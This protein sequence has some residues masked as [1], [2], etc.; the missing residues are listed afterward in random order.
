MKIKILDIYGYGKWVHQSFD[1]DASL[2]V[3]YGP[4][5][6]GKST[7]QSFIKSILFGFPDKRKRKHL[8]NRYEPKHSDI[9]GGRILIEHE[10]LGQ[11]WVERTSKYLNIQTKDGESLPDSI[12]DDILGGLDETLFDYFYGFNIQNLQDLTNIGAEDLN[13]FFLSIGTLGSDKFL[14]VAQAFEKDQEQLYKRNGS[15]PILNQRL[16]DYRELQDKLDKLKENNQRYD[17]L[18]TNKQDEQGIIA[19]LEEK[20]HDLEQELRQTDQL[21]SRYTTYLDD[22][23]VQRELDRLVYTEM[24]S[25][26]PD[27][28]NQAL[29]DNHASESKIAAL[30]ERMKHIE[31][32]LNQLTRLSWARRHADQRLKWKQDIEMAKEKQTQSEQLFRQINE[33]EEIMTHLAI[34]GKFYPEKIKYGQEYEE[35]MEA[36]LTLQANL[37]QEN[38]RL[39]NLNSECKVLLEQRRQ[40]QNHSALT[41]QQVAKLE[42]QRV[43]DEERL[44]QM[45]KLSDYLLGLLCTIAGIVLGVF[46]FLQGKPLTDWLMLLAGGMVL[47]GIMAMVQIFF[48]HRQ[49]I[50]E[51][52]ANPIHQ[53][54][55]EL[56]EDEARYLEQSRG[57]GLEINQRQG[58]I[59]D[60][61]DNIQAIRQSQQTWLTELGFYPDADPEH[62]LKTNP[63]K[64]Y[65][66]AQERHLK[67]QTER[68]QLIRDL[69]TWRDSLKE[70]M[71]RFPMETEDNN[72]RSVIRHVESIEASLVQAVMR[73]EALE[74][75]QKMTQE[76]I[77]EEESK[78]TQRQDVIDQILKHTQSE[79]TL[80]FNHKVRINEEIVNLRQSHAMYQDQIGDHLSQLQA[81]ESKQTLDEQYHRQNQA[82][83]RLK[84]QLTPHMH[85]LANIMVEID[86]LEQDGSYAQ[87]SQTAEDLK[88]EI[89]DLVQEWAE[90]RIAMHLII[91]T[92]KHGLENPVPEMNQRVNEIFTQL[93]G[94]R[95]VEVK[96]NKNHIKVRQFSDLMFEP[97]ELSQGTLEQ[98]YVALRLAFVESAKQR[99]SMPLII[100]DAF[101]N[102]DE[103]RRRQMYLVLKDMS[104]QHQILFFTFDALAYDIFEPDQFIDLETMG[105]PESNLDPEATDKKMEE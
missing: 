31:S 8:Q 69:E 90:K 52:Q 76:S 10:S 6:I 67:Y 50:E 15:N 63:A 23:R 99:V 29:R 60:L 53:K 70:L 92:L 56:K 30:Q 43:N 28:V 62:V 80:D 84:M 61:E 41:R 71:E 87:L 73:A 82:L 2:Q 38:E 20:I 94:G 77:Q 39:D 42:S 48:K 49:Y 101:V 1:L 104:R 91:D 95:Y 7:I 26:M 12:L 54:I 103:Q 89:R 57:L 83:E 19:N 75:R 98:L 3:F 81:I 51:F 5:E 55:E 35:Q 32:D 59:Q 47:I 18:L 21:I 16:N 65:F 11:V 105:G 9:Y 24:D 74:D 33:S 27:K 37:D 72:I 100:D 34:Q 86:Q 88:S 64:H 78:M 4:N 22:Q 40:Y 66:E 13:Q 85:Q 79:N 36:G 96:F 45:T 58:D 68:T 102:F 97:H 93:S 46:G 17:A 25:D 44:L 14:E